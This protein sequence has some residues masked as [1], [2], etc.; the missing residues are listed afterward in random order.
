VTSI[1]PA[2]LAVG[3]VAQ[4]LTIAGTSFLS[5]STVTFNGTAATATYVS[6]TQLTLPLTTA[7]LSA[8][9]EFAVVVT[10]P[11]PGGGSSTATNLEVDNPA[12]VVTAISPS[13]VPLGSTPPTITITGTGFVSG[14]TVTYNGNAETANYVSGTQLTITLSTADIAV[15][16]S[17]PI[18]VTN[19][20]PGGGTSANTVFTVTA[21]GPTISGAIDRGPNTIGGTITAYAV[22]ADGS[23][24]TVPLGS[25][26]QKADGTFSFM[27]AG[28]PSGTGQ[29][30]GYRRHL[31]ERL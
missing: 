8:A 7:N 27:L 12:P 5:T 13:S 6:A 28:F 9:G 24:G 18:V 30:D 3:S 15:A 14:S 26:T 11:A 25:G 31:C 29:T 17:F 19:A 2:K 20:A 22:N 1:S 16:G 23:N 21:P 10:N 4:T